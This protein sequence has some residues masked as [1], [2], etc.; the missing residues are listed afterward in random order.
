M[1]TAK[2]TTTALIKDDTKPVVPVTAKRVASKALPKKP[3]AA[4]ANPVK[5]AVAAKPAQVIVKSA[6]TPKTTAKTATKTIA[7]QE[8]KVEKVKKSKMVRDSFTIPKAEYLVLEA[9]KERAVKLSRVAK[10]SE[11]LRAGIK[12][13]EAMSDAAFLSALTAVPA[14]KTG[15]PSTAS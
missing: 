7:A 15:R 12:A 1:S 9:L 14:I 4:P 13:L 5:R 11:L 2:K 3:T 6:L 10:K 8:I